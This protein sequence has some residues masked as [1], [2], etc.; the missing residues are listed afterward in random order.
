MSARHRLDD[1]RGLA[2][3]PHA[4]DDAFVAPFH[5][6]LQLNAAQDGRRRDVRQPQRDDQRGSSQ[7]RQ[8]PG[9]AGPA[10]ARKEQPPGEPTGL[11]PR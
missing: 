7:R 3:P 10:G 5:R 11:E 4:D 6:A 1:R 9:D 2:V 8:Q